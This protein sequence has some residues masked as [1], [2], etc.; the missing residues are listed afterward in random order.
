MQLDTYC[1][2]TWCPGCGNF[3]ILTALKQAIVDLEKQ[4]IGRE[5]IV[6][7]TG[8]GCHGK[9]VDYLNI[10]TFY[11]LHGR[12]VACA[13]GIKLANPDLKVIVCSGDGDSYNEGI[14]HLIHSAKRNIDI[15]VLIHDNRT[16]ALTTGQFTSTSPKG[17][18]GKSTPEGNVEEPFN[19]LQLILDAGGTFIA[20]GY[21]AKVEHLK[22]LIV[23]GVRHKGF[24][25]IEVL[26][27]CVSFFNSY[28]FY[29]E[30]I[31]EMERENYS[32]EEALKKIREWNYN[33][34][35]SKIPIGIFY[36]VQ[37]LTYE[38]QLLEGL[39]PSKRERRVDIKKALEKHI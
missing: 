29:Q 31:Y 33:G 9:I 18:K 4:G 6:L 25:F 7:T 16:F 1:K 27:P 32:K 12:P 35:D 11:S 10:N 17:F 3:G 26:Q 5:K 20:R 39:N 13:N 23:K 38:E 8:I 19:P 36:Q 14:S 2:N 22:E 24:S 21:S 30:R 37:K 15:T 34:E 28:S